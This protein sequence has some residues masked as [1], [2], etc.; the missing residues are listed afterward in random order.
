MGIADLQRKGHDESRDVEQSL[1]KLQEGETGSG[2]ASD[3]IHNKS[4]ELRPPPGKW[5]GGRKRRRQ[6]ASPV[7]ESA[8]LDCG[9]GRGSWTHTF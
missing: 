7:E 1:W 4:E 8:E 3:F 6:E 2:E 5:L 9:P